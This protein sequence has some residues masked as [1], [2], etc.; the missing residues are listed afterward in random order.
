GQYGELL[1]ARRLVEHA[2][3]G[4]N[5]NRSQGRQ[6]GR[7]V[8]EAL[9]EPAAEDLG[10]QTAGRKALAAFVRNAAEGL[11]Q[12]Q[13]GFGVEPVGAAA[14]DVARQLEVVRRRVVAAQ[15]QTEA[16]LA[17][18]RAVASAHV[19]AADVEGGNELVAEADRLRFG[20]VLN[21]HR[22]AKRLAAG[23]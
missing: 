22:D 7:V 1:P 6:V 17:A 19:A 20:E 9:R 10:R 2:R 8:L 21:R 15:T 14:E 16:V 23:P 4:Q 3:T 11:F 12:D 13:A 5:V 18:G